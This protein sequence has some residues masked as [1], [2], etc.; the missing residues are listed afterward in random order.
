[1]GTVGAT[2]PRAPT[3]AENHLPA[4]SP[5]CYYGISMSQD[6]TIH[7]TARLG[8]PPIPA[9]LSH[10]LAVWG[11]RLVGDELAEPLAL[12]A[13]TAFR[14]R[15]DL[16][17]AAATAKPDLTEIRQAINEM[18]VAFFVLKNLSEKEA[19][20]TLAKYV[21]V[22]HDLPAWAV[23]RACYMMERGQVEDVSLDRP[24]AAPRVREVVRN[25]VLQPLYEEAGKLSAV[26]NA[27]VIY[28][29]S[30]DERKRIHQGFLSLSEELSA[31]AKAEVEARKGPVLE[32]TRKAS[33]ELTMREYRQHGEQPEIAGP[34]LLSRGLAK[35][36]KNHAA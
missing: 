25:I 4:G 35:M 27:Q 11:N 26:L 17:R 32:R 10:S 29:P 3:R 33:F 12:E 28:K 15:L 21:D 5:L 2:I 20:I 30:E 34:F 18:M 13:K 19:A 31:T 36:L 14:Q 8:I 6:L 23:R 7:Q 24:P 16:V 22:V 9:E 1:M